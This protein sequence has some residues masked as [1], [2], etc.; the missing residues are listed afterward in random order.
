MQREARNTQ[1]CH[2]AC[3]A[4]SK[5]V[6]RGPRAKF[7]WALVDKVFLGSTRKFSQTSWGNHSWG[8][9]LFS[10][11]LGRGPMAKFLEALVDKVFLSSTRNFSQTSWGNNSWGMR[12]FSKNVG[13]GP[14]AKFLSGG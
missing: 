1:L 8:T 13:R 10:K 14:R 7:L 12:L 3:A 5:S 2:Q 4:L 9:C 11:K 6:G